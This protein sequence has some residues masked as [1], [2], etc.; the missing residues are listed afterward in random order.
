MRQS[1]ITKHQTPINASISKAPKFG[2]WNLNFIGIWCLVIS[3]AVLSSCGP[4]YKREN[5]EQSVKTLVQ[6]EYKLDVEVEEVGDTLGLRFRSPNLIGDLTSGDEEIY[7]KMNGMFMALIRVVLSTDEPPEF[8]VLDIADSD[9]P[10]FHLVFTRYVEDLR[11]AMAEALS[12]SQNQD[13]LLEEFV[14]GDRHVP[15]DPQDMDL[16]RLMLMAMDSSS[17]KPAKAGAFNLEPVDFH[18]F[19]ER[20]SENVVRRVMKENKEIKQATVL[21]QVSAQFEKPAAPKTEQGGRFRLLLDVG[22]KPSLPLT[23]SFIEQ[24]LLPLAA[25]E[26]QELFKSYRFKN[27]DAITVI[28]KNTGKT[29]SVSGF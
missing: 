11:K 22:S 26:I 14:I 25:K 2:I 19:L 16:V 12:H 3:L 27:F 1:P 18:D 24:R 29:F 10:K 7:R 4:T 13:R 20:V 8:I 15:F 9:N 28:E 17:E 5:I 6:R 23:P 21:R